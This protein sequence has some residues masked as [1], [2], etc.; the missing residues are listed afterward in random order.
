MCVFFYTKKSH[1]ILRY[2]YCIYKS[3][4]STTSF[5][6]GKYVSQGN[7]RSQIMGPFFDI[8]NIPPTTFLNGP[9]NSI[10]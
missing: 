2:A 6:G 3:T 8:L 9:I 7:M 5:G 1:N 10:K 4:Y